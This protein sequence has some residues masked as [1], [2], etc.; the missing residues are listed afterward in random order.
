M[1]DKRLLSAEYC[2]CLPPAQFV[3]EQVATDN[4]VITTETAPNTSHFQGKHMKAAAAAAAAAAARAAG[5]D[6]AAVAAA[7]AAAAAAAAAAPATISEEPEDAYEIEYS[8]DGS[9]ADVDGASA[10]GVPAGLGAEAAAE[11][12]QQQRKRDWESTQR[13]AGDLIYEMLP[14]VDDAAV[15]ST[16]PVTAAAATSAQ[17]GQQQDGYYYGSN[18]STFSSSMFASTLGSSSGS[19]GSTGAA[20]AGG[21]G[22]SSN[23][24]SLEFLGTVA[25]LD[26]GAGSS[27]LRSVPDLELGVGGADERQLLKEM[28]KAQVCLLGWAAWGGN[29][30][31]A[32]NSLLLGQSALHSAA[33]V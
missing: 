14:S 27:Q 11:R 3:E 18:S 19:I 2:I 4:F 20:A 29:A 21:R 8:Q 16:L 13:L 7:V 15:W 22:S 30:A 1:L 23:T 9:A 31:N 6:P 28:S 32:N 24:G 10:T 12:E 33:S 26:S 25:G 17:E 5:A